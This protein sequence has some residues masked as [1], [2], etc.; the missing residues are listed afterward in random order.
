MATLLWDQLG[1][2]VYETGVDRGVLYLTDR[3]GVV[4]NGLTSVEEKTEGVEQTPYY[5]D[6]VRYFIERSPGD[7]AA[8]LNAFTYPDAFLEFEGYQSPDRGFFLDNQVVTA[9]FG[10]S[11]RTRIGNDVSGVALGYKIHILYNLTAIPSNKS[12]DTQD[13]SINPVEFSWDITGVPEKVD[14]Y[15][16]TAHAVFDSRRLSP[17]V[18]SAIEDILYGNAT[19]NARLPSLSELIDLVV[20]LTL[21]VID[22]GDGSWTAIGPDEDVLYLDSTSF[23]ITRASANMIDETSY[24]LTDNKA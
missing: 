17:V 20:G 7:F 5:I 3:T 6:G 1:E 12:Y 14:G 22:H 4:W 23:Q 21:Q 15:R 8:T 2:K 24:T 11:Y 19:T 9:T 10:L 18:L 13:N 16:P